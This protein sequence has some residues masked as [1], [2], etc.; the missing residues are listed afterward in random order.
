MVPTQKLQWN[1]SSKVGSLANI[2]HK[3]GGGKVQIF[4]EKYRPSASARSASEVRPPNNRS[5][6][7]AMQSTASD[8]QENHGKNAPS[9][10]KSNGKEN[11]SQQEQKAKKESDGGSSNVLLLQGAPASTG[12]TATAAKRTTST[13][14]APQPATRKASTDH[15]SNN[16]QK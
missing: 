15:F 11:N 10:D 5:T 13:T 4:D 3:A 1:T 9:G 7:V 6:P 2:R 16:H 14:P 12:S 8:D